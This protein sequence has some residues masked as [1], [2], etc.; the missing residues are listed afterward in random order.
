MSTKN[1]AYYK[2]VFQRKQDQL[3]AARQSVVDREEALVS[4][5][6]RLQSTEKE[7]DMLQV[8]NSLRRNGSGR[9]GS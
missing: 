5:S 1:A 3:D 7:R 6:E 2:S 8:S 9:Y 4:M